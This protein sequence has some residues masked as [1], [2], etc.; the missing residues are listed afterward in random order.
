MCL[1]A[2]EEMAAAKRQKRQALQKE[3]KDEDLAA[4]SSLTAIKQRKLV[5]FPRCGLLISQEKKSPSSQETLS[6]FLSVD[7]S[8]FSFSL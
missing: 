8:D 5:R 4:R 3:I 2:T 7:H 1:L 6:Y